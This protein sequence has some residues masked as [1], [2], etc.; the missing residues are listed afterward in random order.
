MN[1]LEEFKELPAEHPINDIQTHGNH[2]KLKTYTAKKANYILTICGMITGCG[3][4]QING[5]SSLPSFVG[6][7][8][9]YKDDV[10]KEFLQHLKDYSETVYNSGQG[11]TGG[12]TTFVATLG[13]HDYHKDTHATMVEIGFKEVA[14]YDNNAHKGRGHNQKLYVITI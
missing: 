11:S 13:C 6:Q 12:P 5:I 3:I 4:A 2:H 9:A 14:K 10:K 7:A 8:D 1:K